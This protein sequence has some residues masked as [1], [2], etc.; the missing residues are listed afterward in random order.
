MGREGAG[1]KQGRGR[2]QWMF[3]R[4][5]KAL[6]NKVHPRP[7]HHQSLCTWR[8]VGR[9]GGKTSQHQLLLRASTGGSGSVWCLQ[10]GVG[11]FQGRPQQGLGVSSICWDASFIHPIYLQTQSGPWDVGQKPREWVCF[12][13]ATKCSHTGGHSHCCHGLGP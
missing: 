10:A 7:P 12:C 1:H 4:K 3:T 13:W 5:G 9:Q 6:Q 2:G 8:Q 11:S